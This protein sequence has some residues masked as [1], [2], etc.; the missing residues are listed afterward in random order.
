MSKAKKS[1]TA[2]NNSSAAIFVADLLTQVKECLEKMECVSN[3]TIEDVLSWT[4]TC[5]ISVPFIGLPEKGSREYE[6]LRFSSKPPSNITVIGSFLLGTSISPANVDLAIEFPSE[7][8]EEKDQLN[9]RYFLKRAFFLAKAAHA[10]R[11]L[12]HLRDAEYFWMS[13]RGHVIKPLLAIKP[14]DVDVEL[15][16]HVSIKSSEKIKL[17]RFGP[18]KNLVR[19]QAVAEFQNSPLLNFDFDS[20]QIKDSPTPIYNSLILSDML[21]FDHLKLLHSECKRFVALKDAIKLGKV[22]LANRGYGSYAFS[23][24]GFQFSM[25][26]AFLCKIGKID[27][28]MTEI[29]IFKSAMEFLVGTDFSK[30]LGFNNAAKLEFVPKENI[31]DF[32]PNAYQEAFAAIMTEP[33]AGMNIFFDWTREMVEFVKHD[34]HVALNVLSNPLN[35]WESLF[36]KSDKPLD[37]YDS[38]YI[39][40]GFD[41]KLDFM[42]NFGHYA[43]EYIPNVARLKMVAK[44][45]KF[46]L[47]NRCKSLFPLSK[48]PAPVPLAKRL[49]ISDQLHLSLVLDRENSHKLVELGPLAESSDAK[50]FR[51]FWKQ[52]SELRRFHDGSIRE[53]VAWDSFKSKGHLIVLDILKYVFGEHLQCEKIWA[54]DE[55]LEFAWFPNSHFTPINEALENFSRHLRSIK[56]LPLAIHRCEA[57]DSTG[58]MTSMNAPLKNDRNIPLQ[59]T[60]VLIY[61][62][63]SN[64]W[65]E[66]YYGILYAKQ[67]FAIQICRQLED[68]YGLELS[69]TD[70]FFDVQF[71]GFVFR[72]FIYN[73]NESQLLKLQGMNYEEI[74]MVNVH[75][76]LLARKISALARANSIYAPTCRLVKRWL[77][78]ILYPH[79]SEELVEL[80]VSSIFTGCNIPNTVVAAFYRLLTLLIDHKWHEKPLFVQFESQLSSYQNV[81]IEK[82]KFNESGR[83]SI[84]WA[85][86]GESGI[87]SANC[88][89]N[90]KELE[91]LQKLSTVA[92]QALNVYSSVEDMKCVFRASERHFDAVIKL[93]KHHYDRRLVA[94]GEKMLDDGQARFLASLPGF[95]VTRTLI[96]KLQEKWSNCKF[97][98]SPHNDFI[99]VIFKD[100]NSDFDPETMKEA[101]MK[102]Y[103]QGLVRSVDILRD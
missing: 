65:P 55:C 43:N 96:D 29:Q 39:A 86:D 71:D 77:A 30:V 57:I 13:F 99:G 103:H 5:T 16:I 58:R 33:I 25:L 40:D 49:R 74:E 67:A 21:M 18:G 69:I 15:R 24:T 59:V 72:C 34:A 87:W 2:T 38:F 98:P 63:E 7:L 14:K 36:L 73:E 22:W 89:L 76:P 97:Y 46:A 44:K 79:L 3:Q 28:A 53:A 75:A 54:I 93:G 9:Y 50:I 8:L 64:R 31:D 85:S 42:A 84:L 37:K 52:R 90:E 81:L 19:K 27:H 91:Y 51:N 48:M 17:H 62:E 56:G 35:H 101:L 68:Q 88:K 12:P 80:L 45:I 78:D 94:L 100:E 47:G 1:K 60:K 66:D 32:S 102:R 41:L 4:K 23:F 70:D 82:H 10:L 26:C 20:N 92:L 95:S 61:L 6:N 11:D 83:S